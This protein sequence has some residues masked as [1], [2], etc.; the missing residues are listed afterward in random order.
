DSAGTGTQ[1]TLSA[2]RG[3]YESFQIAIQAPQGGLTNVNASISDL[4][5]PNGAVIAKSNFSLFREKYVYV[6][7]SSPNWGGA[8]Q[9][10][11]AGWYP[12]ALIPFADPS[13]GKPLS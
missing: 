12:D 2:A 1:A 8:N 13:T 5:G 10:L 6:R 7:Q 3:E 11:G 9:P 4:S